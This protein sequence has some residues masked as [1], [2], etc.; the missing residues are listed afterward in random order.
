MRADHGETAG[1]GMC[2]DR[3]WGAWQSRGAWRPHHQWRSFLIFV[4]LL[5]CLY[6]PWEIFTHLVFLVKR[7]M[8][9][10]LCSVTEVLTQSASLFLDMIL[11]SVIW[12]FS[13]LYGKLEI[14]KTDSKTS[15][16]LHLYSFLLY[17][18]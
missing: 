4:S 7:L 18:L 11:L 8:L 10:M 14:S 5:W 15:L 12:N 3:G 17:H 9:T 2:G 1:C 13:G 6:L 16:F